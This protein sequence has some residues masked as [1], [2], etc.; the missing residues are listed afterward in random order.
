V[1]AIFEAASSRRASLQRKRA[2]TT[3][4]CAGP[5]G[6]RGA[7]IIAN[8]TN[9][10]HMQ[11]PPVAQRC[12]DV[13]L[14]VT[15]GW[16]LAL[17]GGR[18]TR[19]R[20][21]P[22]GREPGDFGTLPPGTSQACASASAS[23]WAREP[24]SHVFPCPRPRAPRLRPESRSLTA[25]ASPPRAA[26]GRPPRTPSSRPT[27]GSRPSPGRAPGPA[28]RCRAAAAASACGRRWS[29]PAAA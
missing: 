16:K 28:L 1:R 19:R 12:A 23:A 10:L 25:P 3:I 15:A 8:V 13:I 4:L 18:V 7:A 21:G 9:R 26:R 27:S 2:E 5:G 29:L 6:R 24:A 20:E 14:S 17:C 11:P 22:R